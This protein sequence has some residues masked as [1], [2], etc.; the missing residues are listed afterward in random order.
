MTAAFLHSGWGGGVELRSCQSQGHGVLSNY[1]WVD[2]I[3]ELT[4][5]VQPPVRT[6]ETADL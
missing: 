6:D 4:G 5:I 1:K 2:L 3:D